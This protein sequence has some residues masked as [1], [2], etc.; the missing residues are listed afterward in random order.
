MFS[1]SAVSQILDMQTVGF[2]LYYIVL[3]HQFDP[4]SNICL[5]TFSLE[6]EFVHWDYTNCIIF[7]F[8]TDQRL[9]ADKLFF[10]LTNYDKM[11]KT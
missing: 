1:L 7:F 2:Q 5:F 4:I 3:V 10:K 11:W 9:N 8:P 6:H